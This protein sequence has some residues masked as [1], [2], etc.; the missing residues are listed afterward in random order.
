MNG[1]SIASLVA[2]TLKPM[3]KRFLTFGIPSA[4]VV[5]GL[6]MAPSFSFGKAEYTKK[7]GKGCTYCHTAAGKKDLN[8]VG[9]CY[10]EHNHSLEGCTPK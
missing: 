1:V 8:D 9:K 6:M 2:E 3:L 7:E 4:I 10:A 5:G